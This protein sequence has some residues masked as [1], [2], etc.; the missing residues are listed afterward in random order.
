MN[1]VEIRHLTKR[2][3]AFA[4]EDVT[5]D[6]E[7]GLVTGFV[8]ANGSGKTTTIKAV[9]GMIHPDAG[10]AT[11]LPH[12]RIGVV[13][14]SPPYNGEWRARDVG[15]GLAPFYPTWSVTDFAAGLEEAEIDPAAK[16]KDLSRGKGMRLQM[17]AALAHNP[18]LLILD[19][20]TAGVD[21]L[22]RSQMVDALAQYMTVEDHTVWFSTHITSDLDRLADRLV[23]LDR[24]RVV[25][26]GTTEELLSSMRV[27]RGTPERLTEEIR[28]HGLGLRATAVGWE[29]MLPSEAAE[30]LDGVVVE[31]PSIEDLA[32]H[33]AKGVDRD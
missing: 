23:V 31:E 28:S 4:L 26:A 29:V 13:F 20:P 7:K 24:G 30:A 27:V 25:A 21:P 2:Y 5:F 32:V 11:T 33:I 17:V 8:G 12:E 16:V 9:L 6:V 19:E 1:P 18:E 15:L 14:D 22:A 3:P 10:T